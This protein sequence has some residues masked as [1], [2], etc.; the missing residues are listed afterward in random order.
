[1]NI[2][3]ITA[4]S[5]ERRPHTSI[6]TAAGSRGTA[7]ADAS[8]VDIE[9]VGS[10]E[11]ARGTTNRMMTTTHTIIAAASAVLAADVL[12]R[13]AALR[14]GHAQRAAATPAPASS[15]S[16]AKVASLPVKNWYGGDSA[17]PRVASLGL[18][19]GTRDAASHAGVSL[20]LARGGNRRR[21]HDGEDLRASARPLPR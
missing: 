1:M 10:R 14:A 4:V 3:V 12:T 11:G 21:R 16:T 8:A 19:K 5:R 15:G 6:R 9:R 18:A 2:I 7:R 13:A 20:R 17:R